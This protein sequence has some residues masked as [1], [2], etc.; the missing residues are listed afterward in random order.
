MTAKQQ[1]QDL[2]GLTPGQR[3]IL[4]SGLPVAQGRRPYRVSGVPV[5]IVHPGGSASSY[6][7]TTHSIWWRGLRFMH[8][9]FLHPDSECR[10]LLRTLSGQPRRIGSRVRSCRLLRDRIHDIEIEFDTPVDVALICDA[11]EWQEQGPEQETAAADEI[12]ESDAMAL[13]LGESE[14]DRAIIA[15]M[16]GGAGLGVATA[17]SVE[18]TIERLSSAEFRIVVADLDHCPPPAP[19]LVKRLR[20]SGLAAPLLGVTSQTDAGKLRELRQAGLTAA[21]ASPVDHKKFLQTVSGYLDQPQARSAPLSRRGDDERAG[22][23]P[24]YGPG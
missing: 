3:D 1:F 5:V 21:V 18:E 8:G 10:L 13:L 23:K 24:V 9:G 6:L 22:P 12:A 11:S 14:V 19:A 2:L 15:E 16:L 4:L 7:V 20:E 17:S